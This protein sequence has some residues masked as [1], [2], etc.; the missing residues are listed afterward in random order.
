MPTLLALHAHPDDE[1]SKGAATVAR[2]ADAGVRCVLVTATGGEAGDILNP[3]MD[4]P[5][6][7]ERL[8]AGRDEELTKA[9]AI[10][11]FEE[12]I[13]LGYRDSGMKDSAA[14]G[15]AD[16]LA[17]VPLDHVVGR[18]V[19][20]LRRER[21]EIVLGYDEHKRYPHP[22]HVRIHEIGLAAFEA[23]ADGSR[24]PE[25]GPPWEVSKLYA[26]VFTAH[27]IRTLHA[28]VEARGLESPFSEWMQRLGEE[29]EDRVITSVEVS[30]TIERG[31]EALRAHSTQVDPDGF[32]FRV[33]IEVVQDAYPYEDFELLASRVS[34]RATDGAT[35]ADLFAGVW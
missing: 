11:G 20:I 10:I 13:R 1:S 31:R 2:Y 33:P 32:W 9:A 26:P 27:R 6:I 21:P 23:T 29:P 7:R 24:F 19:E 12:V 35:D 4:R 16:A 34:L 8:S 14:N 25:A 5:E 15:H 22:D 30:A 3:V 18:V 17:N 28:A